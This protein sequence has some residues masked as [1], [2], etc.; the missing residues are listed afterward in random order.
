MLYQLLDAQLMVSQIRRQTREECRWLDE[1]NVLDRSYS[2][3]EGHS[4][5]EWLV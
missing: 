5:G 4:L 2:G 3:Q 1:F